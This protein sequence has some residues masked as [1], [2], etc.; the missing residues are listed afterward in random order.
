M[1][2]FETGQLINMLLLVVLGTLFQD[3]IDGNF[4][5]SK[6]SAHFHFKLKIKHLNT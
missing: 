5:T 2:K 4:Q 1:A 6:I 3:D